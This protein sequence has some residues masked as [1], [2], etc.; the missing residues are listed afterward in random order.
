MPGDSNAQLGRGRKNYKVVPQTLCR[1][2]TSRIVR[3]SAK[4]FYLSLADT[5]DWWDGKREEKPTKNN[6]KYFGRK[7]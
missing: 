1:C 5:V 3:Q 4:K 6:R 7:E 2:Q